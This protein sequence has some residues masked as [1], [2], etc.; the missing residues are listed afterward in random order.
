MIMEAHELDLPSFVISFSLAHILSLPISIVLFLSACS[1]VNI[2]LII[3][4]RHNIIFA[5][6]TSSSSSR[7]PVR[8]ISHL[9]LKH[10]CGSNLFSQRCGRL[11]CFSFWPAYLGWEPSQERFSFLA[12]ISE[13]IIPGSE[14]QWWL[15]SSSARSRASPG[16]V[17]AFWL[18][19]F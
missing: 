6:K 11:L 8:C 16:T 7:K 13:C 15:H 1:S 19:V 5:P 9:G 17:L 2:S 14:C 12:S 4:Y 18:M 3:P 10:F